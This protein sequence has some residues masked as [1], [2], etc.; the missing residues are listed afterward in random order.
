MTPNDGYGAYT[1]VIDCGK[2]MKYGEGVGSVW[3]G[4]DLTVEAVGGREL[5]IAWRRG[6]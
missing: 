6:F 4:V 3:S 5:D 2:G 1:L